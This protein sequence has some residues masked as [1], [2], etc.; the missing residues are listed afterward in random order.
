MRLSVTVKSIGKRKN[1]LSRIPVELQQ[2]PQTL[3]EL[4]SALVEWNVRGLQERQQ[5]LSLV[6]YLTEGE[7]QERAENGKVGFG[8]IYNDAAPDVAKAID[9]AIL[10]FEDGLY[11]V[12]I[13]EQ[14]AEALD[15]PLSLKEDDDVV[16][17]R[18]TMLAGS[19]W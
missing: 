2:S 10:A 9:T 11:R 15:A 6:P 16:L 1:A 5:Q 12:F 18:F 14:E 13:C 17:I 4:I 7:V 19:L 8:A 3:R